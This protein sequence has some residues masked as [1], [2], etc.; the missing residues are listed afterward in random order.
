MQKINK[1]LLGVIVC[2]LLLLL[3]LRAPTSNAAIVWEDDFND[4]NYDNWTIL[5]GTFN[6]TNQYLETTDPGLYQMHQIRHDSSVAYGFWSFDL[7]VNASITSPSYPNH[8]V[9]FMA[10]ELDDDHHA[11][12]GFELDVITNNQFIGLRLS[13]Y[14]GEEGWDV[15]IG[16]TISAMDGWQEFNITRDCMGNFDF[17][18]NGTLRMEHTDNA[19]FPCNLFVWRALEYN[20]IDNVVISELD[21]P[22]TTTIS[23]ELVLI[24]VGVTIAVVVLVLVVVI[25]LRRRRS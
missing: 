10:D 2:C 15:L 14:D 8:I 19:I 17:F 1:L 5:E 13:K 9:L 23:L 12:F 6:A 24:G 4:G 11:Y 16:V 20:A 18:L 21:S 25:V 22:C 7:Y 3:T